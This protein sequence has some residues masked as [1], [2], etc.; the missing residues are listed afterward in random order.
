MGEGCRQ[1]ARSSLGRAK[2][3][4]HFWFLTS[5]LEFTPPKMG[6][7]LPLLEKEDSI[8]SF[9]NPDGVEILFTRF[10]VQG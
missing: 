6:D 7:K 10:G 5:L 4:F 1:E 2:I 3:R 9:I 8:F